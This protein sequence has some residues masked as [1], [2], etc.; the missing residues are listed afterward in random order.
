MQDLSREQI[1]ESTP[2]HPYGLI[3]HFTGKCKYVWEQR[4]SSNALT[5]L[6]YPEPRKKLIKELKKAQPLGTTPDGKKIYLYKHVRKSSVIKEIGRL[7]ELSFRAVGEG[8]N[9]PSDLDKYDK[10]YRHIILWDPKEHEIIGAYRIGETFKLIAKKGKRALYSNELFKYGSAFSDHF[11][12]GIELGR[13]FVQ[14]KYWGNRS[15]DNLWSGIG[16]YL[17]ANP[18]V[19]FLFGAVSISND[20]PELAKQQ[21]ASCYSHFFKPENSE[22]FAKSRTPFHWD[23]CINDSWRNMEYSEAVSKL[24]NELRQNRLSIP[25]LLKHYTDLCHPA[26]IK[27]I[28]FNVDPD[29]SYCIDALMLVDLHHIKDKKYK[30]YIAPHTVNNG[31]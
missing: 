18:N 8:T 6:A 20:Y 11:T 28:D 7:R 5:G 17:K 10:Y 9:T 14:P 25:T 3:E 21:I 2:P 31:V 4:K 22:A 15:L 24:K 1:I 16:A 12:Y 26:G 23:K 29:F 30:R 13:S 19:R 27:V